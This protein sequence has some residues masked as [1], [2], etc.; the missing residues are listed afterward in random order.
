MNL[1]LVF[2]L[3]S[4]NLNL[5]LLKPIN[6][7]LNSVFSKSMNLNLKIKNKMNGSNPGHNKIIE[8]TVRLKTSLTGY[9]NV[10]YLNVHSHCRQTIIYLLRW[11]GLVLFIQLAS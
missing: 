7:S 11:F 5:V 8:I 4:M 6:L 10:I 2:F 1:N 3:T 9:Q